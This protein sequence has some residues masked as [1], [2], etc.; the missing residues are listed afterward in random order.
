[1]IEHFYFIFP[2]RTYES[3]H[4]ST[5]LAIKQVWFWSQKVPHFF[6]QI[7]PI[8]SSIFLTFWTI[9]KFDLDFGPKTLKTYEILYKSMSFFNK[10][11]KIIDQS[12][13]R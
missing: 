9:I 8:T 13:G 7:A 11:H 2:K 6:S 4:F 10:I 3:E 12:L 1:M 5:L